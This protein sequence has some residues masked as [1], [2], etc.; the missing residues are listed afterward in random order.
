MQLLK[1]ILFIFNL[2]CAGSSLLCG[3]FLQLQQV[4]AALHLQCSGFSMLWILL[5]WSMDSR[6]MG[7]SSC[8][9]QAQ[10]L[11]IPGPRAQTQQLQHTGLVAP[12]QVRSLRPGIKPMSPTLAGGFFHAELPGK[13]IFMQL[14]AFFFFFTS[15]EIDSHVAYVNTLFLFIA[16]WYSLV[17]MNQFLPSFTSLRTFLECFQSLWYRKHPNIGFWVYI[18]FF[19]FSWVN[20]QKYDF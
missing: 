19:H 17:Q 5:L 20:T 16:E 6:H 15:F 18:F 3:L 9:A 10:Q 2:G 12:Q 14:F 13:P 4:G 11:Q 7:F 1:K 8:H